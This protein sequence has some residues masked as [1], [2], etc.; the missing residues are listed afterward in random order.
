MP[1]IGPKMRK[2]LRKIGC[3]VTFTSAAKLNNILYNK[4]VNYYQTVTAVF[5]N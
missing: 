4:K 5:T 1:I 2:E 3:K